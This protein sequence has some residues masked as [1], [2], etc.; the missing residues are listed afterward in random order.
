MSEPA[1]TIWGTDVNVQLTKKKFKDF[2]EN[3]VEDFPS[4]D[5]SPISGS[6]PYYLTKLDEVS[7]R[8]NLEVSIFTYPD[9]CLW[10]NSY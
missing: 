4:V 10:L 5:E 8:L 3:F 9:L 7:I 2:L 6:T 1:L